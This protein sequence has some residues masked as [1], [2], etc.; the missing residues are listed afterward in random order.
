MSHEINR[1][2]ADIHVTWIIQGGQIGEG[3]MI[4][5]DGC[6]YQKALIVRIKNPIWSDLRIL[7]SRNSVWNTQNSSPVWGKCCMRDSVQDFKL[8]KKYYRSL[9]L[10][11]TWRSQSLI[12]YKLWIRFIKYESNPGIMS[13]HHQWVCYGMKNNNKLQHEMSLNSI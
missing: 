13:I 10:K 2:R 7:K 6:I 12:I 1:N 3:N 4:S 11:T 8:L 9:C 5:R